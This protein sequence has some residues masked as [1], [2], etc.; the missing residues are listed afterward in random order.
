MQGL[1]PLLV[2]AGALMVSRYY[3]LRRIG[4]PFVTAFAF[5]SVLW[6][7]GLGLAHQSAVAPQPSPFT[8]GRCWPATPR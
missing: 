5:V 8:V 6:I 2:V 3:D 1:I 4:D 7:I